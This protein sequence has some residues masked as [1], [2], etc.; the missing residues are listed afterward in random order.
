MSVI[1]NFDLNVIY[2]NSHSS[3]AAVDHPPSVTF[4][5]EA[6]SSSDLLSPSDPRFQS[7]R[8]ERIHLSEPSEIK[9]SNGRSRISLVNVT[10]NYG[11]SASLHQFYWV[12][13]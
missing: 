3:T 5:R 1:N 8:E 13:Q 6:P 4:K 2:R 12:S 7:R 11:T 9:R 10:D